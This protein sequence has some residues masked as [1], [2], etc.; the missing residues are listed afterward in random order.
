MS[1]D[2][3][4]DG[5]RNYHINL[6]KMLLGDYDIMVTMAREGGK[7]S[8]GEAAKTKFAVV[9]CAENGRECS[10]SSSSS[11]SGEIAGEGVGSL[12]IECRRPSKPLCQAGGGGEEGSCSG[13]G[14]CQDDVCT[15]HGDWIGERCSHSLK[16]EATYMPETDPAVWEGRCRQGVA[17]STG[18]RELVQ[19]L[20]ELHSSDMCS[21]HDIMLFSSRMHGLGAQV[22]Y[23]TECLTTAWTASQ[24]ALVVPPSTGNVDC[25][26]QAGGHSLLSELFACHLSPYAQCDAASLDTTA[27]LR[28]P[29]EGLSRF[30]GGGGGGGGG[31]GDGGDKDKGAFWWRSHLAWFL[32]RP[33]ASLSASIRL[34]KASIGWSQGEFGGGG[35]VLGVHVRHG[36]ACMHAQISN[37][38]PECIPFSAYV[39]RIQEMRRMYGVSK[40]FVATDD[41]AVVDEARALEGFKVM[42]LDV[43]RAM[44]S[45]DW[46]LEFR[47]QGQASGIKSKVRA[48]PHFPRGVSLA[49]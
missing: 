21:N 9:D 14:L 1:A 12:Y 6:G 30:D 16:E 24:G 5:R 2:D 43:D 13:H 20:E 48:I 23:L 22:H 3:G 34:V 36:D 25:S 42:S 39:E 31:G 18:S 15:C 4:D 33:S 37:F 40:I 8:V 10:S 35:G 44:L 38:R 41:P 49:Q 26:S 46:F 17:W 11:S 45:G 19:R 7:G 27:G 28:Q 47:T 32:I 29:E